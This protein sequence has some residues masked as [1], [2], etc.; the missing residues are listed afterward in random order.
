MVSTI[1]MVLAIAGSDC[2]AGAGI[3]ADIK[4]S[5]AF[6]AFAATAITAVTVQDS[7]GVQQVELLDA[8]LVAAQASA[9]LADYPV[10][11]IKLGM[12]GCAATVEALVDVLQHYRHI[13]LVLDPVILASSG[14]RLLSVE[15]IAAMVEGLLP[16]ATLVTPNRS[17]LACLSGTVSAGN[18][19]SAN[20]WQDQAA[21]LLERGCGAV[22]LTGGDSD[23]DSCEDWLF[24]PGDAQ[25]FRSPRVKTPHTHGTGCT[26]SSAIA[27]GLAQGQT[28]VEAISAAKQYVSEALQVAERLPGGRGRKGLHHLYRFEV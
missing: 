15:G 21:A 7:T 20:G 19:A 3:Q 12:L 10:T 25:V 22:L 27:A 23:G 6:G 9:I 13:P 18:P 24:T 8:Q 14:A 2:S 5:A 4:T 28:L 11:A 1:P 26:L 17:E 16:L